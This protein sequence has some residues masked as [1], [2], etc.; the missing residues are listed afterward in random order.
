MAFDAI[1]GGPMVDSILNAMEAVMGASQAAFS[2]YGTAMLKQVYIYGSLNPEPTML[3]RTY[4]SS[5]SVSRFLVLNALQ[6]FGSETTLALKN[7]IAAELSTTFASSYKGTISL[8]DVI[9]PEFIKEFAR[10]ATGNKFLVN[11]LR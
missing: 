8:E 5:W 7:R 9:K 10:K 4:G 6:K 11:P 3:T 2:R 1:A